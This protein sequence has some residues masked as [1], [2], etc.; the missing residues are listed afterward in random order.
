MSFICSKA[1]ALGGV[2]YYPGD[3]IPDDAVLPGRVRTLKTS[4]Y[5]TDVTTGSTDMPVATGFL[6]AEGFEGKVIIPVIRKVDGDTAEALAV[7]LT[8]D[9]VQQAFAIMQMTVEQA[10]EE[11]EKIS[12]EGILIVL[13][14]A[15]TRTG[16]KKAAQKRAS[17][18]SYTGQEKNESTGGNETTEGNNGMDTQPE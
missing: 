5:I 2:P 18:L 1:L 6:E 14:A 10:V 15:D 4:G 7:P 13:H 16:V 3:L 8:E 12:A 17:T 11:I 9:E